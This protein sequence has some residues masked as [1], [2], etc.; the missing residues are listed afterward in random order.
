LN[1]ALASVGSRSDLL[2]RHHNLAE[3]AHHDIKHLA[4]APLEGVP[5]SI[6]L[7]PR[8]AG[9]IGRRDA[10]GAEYTLLGCFSE[11]STAGINI[12][13]H[14]VPWNQTTIQSCVA[15]CYSAASEPYPYAGVISGSECRCDN[16][17]SALATQVD[18]SNCRSKC[19]N[20]DEEWCGGD[21]SYQI[22]YLPTAPSGTTSDTGP[23]S[24]TSE[25]PSPTGVVPAQ[26]STVAVS[27]D[28][29]YA[30]LGCYED[31]TDILT[32]VLRGPSFTSSSMTPTSCASYC[33]NLGYPYA[34]TESGGD[35]FCGGT[36][37]ADS[38]LSNQCI[39]ACAGDST[40]ACGAPL[41]ISV[42]KITDP[43]V[44]GALEPLPN[45]PSGEWSSVGC[46]ID[47]TTT[48]VMDTMVSTIPCSNLSV[49][50]CTEACKASGY[51]LAGLEYGSQCFCSNTAPS[52]Q[53]DA[54]DCD[55]ACPV[56]G[57]SCGGAL[58]LDV[59]TSI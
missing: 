1:I 58:R 55:M 34:G 37:F 49:D 32:R 28:I 50:A 59:Y 39:Q 19:A 27:T 3:R 24:S 20:G 46:F 11:L 35:C 52:L 42:Y 54:H 41:R 53:A 44:L 47:D 4:R 38:S 18:Q 51:E 56:G 30:Y 48:R 10:S 8:T 29:S 9:G 5:S 40:L 23:T 45:S 6:S 26:P 2:K 16:A 31:T 12:L 21:S 14:T 15:S 57:G 7:K 36:V 33:S 25:V 22:Y 17:M 13:N 43:S